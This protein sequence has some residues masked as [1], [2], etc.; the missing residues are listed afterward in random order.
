M[1]YVYL[2]TRRDKDEAF[3][4]GIGSDVNYYRSKT[5]RNRN[6][7][8]HNIVD[9]LN[10]EY[11][12][13][14]LMDNISYDYA[15]EMEK[16]FI[17]LYGRSN[18]GKGTLCNLTDG[19]EGCHGLVH[20][21]EAR[22][23]MGEPNKGKTISEEHKKIISEFHTGKKHS[24]EWK[25]QMSKRMSGER[26]HNYGKKASDETRARMSLSSHK[27]ESN[28]QSKLKKE[29]ILKIRQ[30]SK[31]GMSQRKIANTFSV[32]KNTIASILNGITWK[33]I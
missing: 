26:N 30:L 9:K 20:S 10:G 12:I 21:E 22:R 29:D 23:K 5:N 11:D 4:V 24:D 28:S 2:H 18:L 3:Y 32:S 25:M 8:W 16:Y 17:S 6:K 33:H 1:A 15:R 7:H 19:G 13:H 27:G 31:E 14:I